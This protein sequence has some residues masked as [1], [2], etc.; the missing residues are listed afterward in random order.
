M[1]YVGM[2]LPQGDQVPGVRVRCSRGG[3]TILAIRASRAQ[4]VEKESTI[5][6]DSGFGIVFG[7]SKI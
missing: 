6:F 3:A 1:N 5:A 4:F 2:N 7:K